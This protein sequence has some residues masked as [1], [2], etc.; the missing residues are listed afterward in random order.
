MEISLLEKIQNENKGLIKTSDFTKLKIDY[1][2]IQRLIKKGVIEKVKNGYYCLTGEIKDEEAL[3]SHLFP[4][5]V[6]CMYS[7]LYYYG[8][9]KRMPNEWHIAV[10]K[11]T[12]KSR[13]KIDYPFIKPYYTEPDYLY[14]GACD[15]LIKNYP[16]KIYNKERLICDCIK[17]EDKMN[18][19][20]FNY[21]ISKYIEEENKNISD[22]LEYG[23]LRRVSKRLDSLLGV[24]L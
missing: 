8:Y 6:M 21:L 2:G 4:D 11:D 14:V 22:L 18:P 24:W 10:D 20:D 5:G 23:K 3:V 19:S 9:T 15:I 16:M 13:F 7:A 12:S 1:R 17:Y